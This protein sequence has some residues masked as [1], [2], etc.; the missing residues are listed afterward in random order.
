M[1]AEEVRLLQSLLGRDARSS[2][3][4]L[5]SPLS[6]DELTSLWAS[7]IYL[8]SGHREARLH[9][10]IQWAVYQYHRLF[11]TEV[12]ALLREHPATS[13]DEDG[14]PFWKG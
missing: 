3:S 5:L 4:S 2:P 1:F 10:C 14:Q 12:Q 11:Q 7:L 13:L 8:S 9:A 6:E